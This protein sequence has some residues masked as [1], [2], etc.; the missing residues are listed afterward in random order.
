MDNKKFKLRGENHGQGVRVA[1]TNH[2]QHDQHAYLV[3]LARFIPDLPV[4]AL[5]KEHK[6]RLE[7]LG[8]VWSLFVLGYIAFSSR[9]DQ[10]PFFRLVEYSLVRESDEAKWGDV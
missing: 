4:L 6:G 5:T 2:D 10:N 9:H 8:S 7:T 3:I 1:T